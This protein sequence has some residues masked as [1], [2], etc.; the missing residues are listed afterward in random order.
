MVLINLIGLSTADSDMNIFL[1]TG[2]QQL[3]SNLDSYINQMVH[4]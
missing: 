4:F 2:S 3:N 1:L